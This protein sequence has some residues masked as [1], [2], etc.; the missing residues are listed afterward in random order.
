MIT[1]ILQ[2]L[3]NAC[4][5]WALLYVP[6]PRFGVVGY[7]VASRVCVPYRAAER[8]CKNLAF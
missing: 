7:S 4:V 2:N 6:Y 3:D 5:G 1:E 8:S